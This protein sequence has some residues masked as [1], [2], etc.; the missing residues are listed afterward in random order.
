MESYPRRRFVKQCLQST[1]LAL[2]A[3]SGLVTGLSCVQEDNL[4]GTIVTVNGPIDPGELGRTLPHEHIMV[5]FIGADQTG[6]HRYDVDEVFD[7]MLPYLK[8]IKAQGVTGFIECT[9]MYLA[10]DPELLLRL[11]RA[12]GMH[13][14]TPT[15]LYKEPYLPDYAFEVSED[16]LA[17]QWTNEILGGIAD[18][19][20]RA[21][22]IKIAVF[23]ESLK[24]MQRKIVRTACRT[25]N[26]TGASIACHTGF[27]PAALEI[28]DIFEEENT[29]PNALIVVHLQ[30][31]QDL[32]SH[33]EIGQR[34]AWLEYDNIGSW[35]SERHINLIMEMLE[36]G[37]RDQIL[38]SQDR[39]WYHVGEDKGGEIKPFTHFLAEFMPAMLAAGIDQATM[40]VL[41]IDNPAR[42]FQFDVAQ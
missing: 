20:I 16:E 34:G 3:Q 37:F 11:S 14:L 18:T 39:G 8:A 23:R 2:A 33:G 32:R 19:G 31:E 36:R 35:P 22:F 4:R 30:G 42:A 38:L 5:D 15:G 29:P 6:K 10:R 41:T 40:D 12:T 13:I 21:G 7:I 26:A 24:P 28:L 27:G 17:A 25:H 9:P 1:G